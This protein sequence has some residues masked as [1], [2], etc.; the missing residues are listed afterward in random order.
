[1]RKIL[2]ILFIVLISFFVVKHEVWMNAIYSSLGSEQVSIKGMSKTFEVACRDLPVS[3]PFCMM[4]YRYPFS[5]WSDVKGEMVSLG[6]GTFFGGTIWYCEIGKGIEK[7]FETG[8]PDGSTRF[9]SNYNFYQSAV[10]NPK[11]CSGD[12][13]I[14]AVQDP[15]SPPTFAGWRLGSLLIGKPSVVSAYKNVYDFFSSY[16]RAI[17]G[18]L[19]LVFLFTAPKREQRSLAYRVFCGGILALSFMMFFTSGLG[20]IL[21]PSLSPYV[22]LLVSVTR[23]VGYTYLLFSILSRTKNNLVLSLSKRLLS[24]SGASLLSLVSIVLFLSFSGNFD[25]SVVL[26]FGVSIFIGAL[27][28]GSPTLIIFGLLLT[29]DGLAIVHVIHG[30]P[31]YSSVP[32]LFIAFLYDSIRSIFLRSKLEDLFQKADRSPDLFYEAVNFVSKHLSVNRVTISVMG[33]KASVE[34]FLI[35]K[36]GPS[37]ISE[38]AFSSNIFAQVAI[39]RQPLVRVA[40]DSPEMVR[41]CGSDAN[42]N[43]QHGTEFCVYPLFHQGRFYGT[44]NVTGYSKMSVGDIP[45]LELFLELVTQSAFRIQDAVYATN[46]S[47]HSDESRIALE[48]ENRLYSEFNV[49]ADRL[50][51]SLDEL[52]KS[53]EGRFIIAT[54]NR[55]QNVFQLFSA[56][57]VSPESA[58]GIILN[59]PK[60][61][62]FD[63]HSLIN[64]AFNEKR[65]VFIDNLIQF[66]SIY[67]K[68]MIDYF[69]NDRTETVYLTPVLGLDGDVW[70]TIWAEYKE[71]VESRIKGRNEEVAKILAHSARRQL[72]YFLKQQSHTLTQSAMV[73]L[74]SITSQV[75]HDIRSPLAALKV[76]SA[77]GDLS[78]EEKLVL[79]AAVERVHDIANTL[80]GKGNKKTE[81]TIQENSNQIVSPSQLLE[82]VIQEKKVQYRPKSGIKIQLE[83]IRDFSSYFVQANAV[84]LERMISNLIDNAVESIED[85]G[86]IIVHFAVSEDLLKITIQDNGKGIPSEL[87]GKLGDRGVTYGKKNGSGLGLFHAKSAMSSWKGNLEIQSTLGRGTSIILSFPLVQSS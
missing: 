35:S 67:P 6:A 66:D 40:L 33:E 32:F 17:L 63:A 44:L 38:P 72:E 87:I 14:E 68:Y 39:S 74:T 20:D 41:I 11:L 62:S 29:C 8:S 73:N 21:I 86:D 12:V 52:S 76:I 77:S 34:S 78:T 28:S 45:D 31:T 61:D 48:I 64:I 55:E 80:A 18:I 82:K 23:C 37:R 9:R 42:T 10:I 49:S 51:Q 47:A 58:E 1:M 57:Q 46:V 70:G 4:G 15:Y 71:D 84:T 7:I 83:L 53:L 5:S 54:A 16:L 65:D 79:K 50:K 56:H 19:A 43:Y 85:S 59:T 3:T 75:A 81:S 36:S 24:T 22:M 69:K 60:I 26:F 13:F 25:L 30:F 2:T 27:A